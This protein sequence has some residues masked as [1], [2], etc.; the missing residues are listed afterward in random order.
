M[1]LSPK[2]KVIF[3]KTDEEVA[4]DSLVESNTKRGE[5]TTLEDLGL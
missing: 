1:K 3:P 2:G 5:D 4:Q